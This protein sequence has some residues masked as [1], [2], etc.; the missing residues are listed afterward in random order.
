MYKGKKISVAMATYNGEKFI[1]EQL[2]SILNQ[3]VPPDEII[4]SDDGSKDKT[5]DIVY[6]IDNV[7]NTEIKV[8]TNNPNHGFVG[9]FEWAITHTSGDYIFL[10]DQDDIW[11]EDKVEKVIEVFLTHPD[12]EFVAHNITLIKGSGEVID[13]EHYSLPTKE[14]LPENGIIKLSRE[15]YLFDN[16]EGLTFLGMSICFD[17][18]LAESAIPLQGNGTTHDGWLT[19]RAILDDGAYFLNERLT[20]YRLHGNNSCGLS[21]WHGNF[22]EKVRRKLKRIIYAEGYYLK[23]AKSG[24]AMKKS[25]EESGYKKQPGYDA[26]DAVRHI[27]KLAE[28]IYSIE[29]SGRIA[30]AGKLIKLFIKD[31][32]YRYSGKAPFVME[33]AY[34]LLH[35]RKYRVDYIERHK[36]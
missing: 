11:T 33:L 21:V 36:K 6:G 8:I 4:V 34:I 1:E 9:N 24:E 22:F 29:T 10:S 32:Y 5:L 20:K 23:H 18:R 35:S 30:G 25:I 19:F 14:N 7:G 12:A 17:R 26:I 13:A 16:I 15:K 31:K 2:L 28:K 3:T 27:C